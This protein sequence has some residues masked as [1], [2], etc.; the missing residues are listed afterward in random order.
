MTITG[1]DGHQNLGGGVAFTPTSRIGD[2]TVFYEGAYVGTVYADRH[3]L[4]GGEATY[5]IALD[6]ETSQELGT[7]FHQHEAITML[8]DE[9]KKHPFAPESD[10]PRSVCGDCNR[11]G[12]SPYHVGDVDTKYWPEGLQ[13]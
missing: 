6:P 2:G 3:Y 4:D 5:F 11:R 1:V 9:A 7:F 13:S 12:D 8:V 10:D